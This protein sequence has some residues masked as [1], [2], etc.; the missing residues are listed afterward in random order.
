MRH[1]SGELDGLRLLMADELDLVAGGDGEDTDDNPVAEIT[2]T[3][4]YNAGAQPISPFSFGSYY[5]GGGYGTSTGPGG[6]QQMLPAND[7]PC[8]QAAPPA[9]G[10]MNSMAKFVGLAAIAKTQSTGHEFAA[11]IYRDFDGSLHESQM[12]EGNDHSAPIYNAIHAIPQGATVV[13]WIHS[14]PTSSIDQTMPSHDQP[15]ADDYE[16]LQSMFNNQAS[17]AAAQRGYQID[18]NVVTYIADANTGKVYAYDKNH[19]RTDTPGCH[20]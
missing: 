15:D 17:G 5:Y 9:L 18:P 6:D 7:T 10:Q 12:F 2:V 16:V 3:G 19:V 13:G 8:V 14:H 1:F 20:L 11:V 4:S